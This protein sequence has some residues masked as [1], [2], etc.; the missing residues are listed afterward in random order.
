MTY[1]K[2]NVK[3]KIFQSGASFCWLYVC[4]LKTQLTADIFE[5]VCL[6]S[7]TSVGCIH[8]L[9]KLKTIISMTTFIENEYSIG[10]ILSII[11]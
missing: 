8:S 4:F 3:N 1:I 10:Y 11:L 7:R 5:T 6:N 9:C 2:I